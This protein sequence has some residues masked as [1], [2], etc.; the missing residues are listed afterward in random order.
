MF[1][2]DWKHSG[3]PPS[4]KD[5]AGGN[6]FNHSDLGKG[7]LRYFPFVLYHSRVLNPK[8]LFKTNLFPKSWPIF[9]L[10]TLLRVE[11][12]DFVRYLLTTIQDYK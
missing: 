6:E 4:G 2:G 11:F 12:K 8:F 5:Q 1:E 3:S 7:V 10:E 9:I